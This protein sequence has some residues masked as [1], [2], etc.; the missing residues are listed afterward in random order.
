MTRRS[1]VAVISIL[2]HAV[3]VFAAMT[4]DLWRPI[5]EWPT[6]RQA[7][8]YVED[9]PRPVRLA[10]IELPKP[11]PSRATTTAPASAPPSTFAT[12]PEVAPTQPPDGVSRETGREGTITGNRKLLD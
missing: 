1:L 11:A 12:P 8:A 5:T 9:A 6:L 2:V 3:V 7:M 4:A 10:N